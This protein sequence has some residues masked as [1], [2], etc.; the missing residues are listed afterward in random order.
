MKF[1]AAILMVAFLAFFAFAGTRMVV[2]S[3]PEAAT[4]DAEVCTNIALN[5][6]AT[7]L[8][9]LTFS[10]G[11]DACE[12]N[13][14]LVAIGAD[15]DND[16]DLSLDEAAIVFGCDCGAWYRADLRTGAVETATTNAL[17]IGKGQFVPAW[18]RLKVVRRGF[19]EIGENVEVGEDRVRFDIRIR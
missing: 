7:R 6:D 1:G 12:T 2:P 14:V 3:L 10:V 16:G 13:E 19:G 9:T 4:P 17:V 18:N 15:G 5:V 8:R 11:F